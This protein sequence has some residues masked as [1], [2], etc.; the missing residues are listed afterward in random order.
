MV[1]LAGEQKQSSQSSSSATLDS[2]KIK[3][4][5]QPAACE[6]RIMY[7]FVAETPED[8]TVVVCVPF[9]Q[10]LEFTS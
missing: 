1:P 3:S 10:L 9:Q 4:S 6:V 7:T 8:L 2:T 5:P